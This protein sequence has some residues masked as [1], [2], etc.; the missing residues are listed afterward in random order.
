MIKSLVKK[1]TETLKTRRRSTLTGKIS[2]QERYMDEEKERMAKFMTQ[3]DLSD[4][5]VLG[6]DRD[7]NLR[8]KP[9][10][11]KKRV[12]KMYVI[13][14]TKFIQL[15]GGLKYPKLHD[16]KTLME[17]GCLEAWRL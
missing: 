9:P 10:P 7:K 17:M 1:L 8:K 11:K 15:Y 13:S 6:K 3:T 14:V 4:S 16:F 12:G 2:P 5:T